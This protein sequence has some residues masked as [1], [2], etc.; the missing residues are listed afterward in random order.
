MT[1]PDGFRVEGRK[2][3]EEFESVA[4]RRQDRLGLLARC[5]GIASSLPVRRSDCTAGYIERCCWGISSTSLDLGSIT[6]V[7]GSCSHITSHY[8][9]YWLE[10]R[11]DLTSPI[12]WEKNWIF[13]NQLWKSDTCLP[14]AL[15]CT[16][17]SSIWNVYGLNAH[18][19]WRL[20]RFSRN[21]IHNCTGDLNG[22]LQQNATLA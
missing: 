7:A 2:E 20:S 5:T 9:L 17:H 22:L 11:R 3:R 10:E 1:K 15:S 12:N 16:A 4:K 6:G 14:P 21:I 8:F 13:E 19:Q 18:N